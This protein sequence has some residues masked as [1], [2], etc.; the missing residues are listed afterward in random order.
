MHPSLLFYISKGVF[1]RFGETMGP[2][3]RRV[4]MHHRP[5]TVRCPRLCSWRL[6]YLMRFKRYLRF[7][8]PTK[9]YWL[10]ISVQE[11]LVNPMQLLCLATGS[12]PFVSNETSVSVLQLSSWNS[13][14][15]QGP[16]R[17]HTWPDKSHWMDV[18]LMLTRYQ[19]FPSLKSL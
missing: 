8:H 18:F 10:I 3:P 19:S 15:L 5:F 2:L 11:L 1:V 9:G 12:S 6:V 4:L 13:R 17:H 14:V 7:H 16:L